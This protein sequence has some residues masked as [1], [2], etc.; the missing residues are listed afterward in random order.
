MTKRHMKGCSISLTVREMQTKTS[1]RCHLTL[2]RMTIIK[3]SAKTKYWRGY[4]EKGT[5]LYCDGDVNCYSH[6]GEQYRDY[7]KKTKNRTL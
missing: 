2:V 3:K 5:L 1:M 4:G 7:L 6:Y